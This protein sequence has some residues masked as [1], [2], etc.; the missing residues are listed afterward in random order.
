MKKPIGWMSNSPEVLKELSQ[1][2]GGKAGECS[3]TGQRHATCSG[4]V[5]RE[6]AIYPAELCRAILSGFYR[7]LQ[8][9]GLVGPGTVGMDVTGQ[10]RE[11]KSLAL[12]TA[13]REPWLSRLKSNLRNAQIKKNT[14][15]EMPGLVGLSE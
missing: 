4:S 9:D 13:S 8:K 3:E 7:Q 5:A 6:A 2:C 11:A 1:R 12:I 14:S 15:I 10:S